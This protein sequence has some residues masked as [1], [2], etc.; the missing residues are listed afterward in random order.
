M[1]LVG[2]IVCL[3][4]PCMLK[5]SLILY[6]QDSQGSN[7]IHCCCV[8][9]VWLEFTFQLPSKCHGDFVPSFK[10]IQVGLNCIY[11]GVHG[12]KIHSISKWTILW[13]QW[14]YIS[15]KL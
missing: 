12:T 4:L 5:A 8:C 14:N 2:I 7:Y 15:K 6:E 10:F 11:G 3:S 13:H 1:K 9:L